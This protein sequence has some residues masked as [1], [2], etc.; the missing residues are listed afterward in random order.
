[1][2]DTRT[3]RLTA[4]PLTAA[5]WEPFGWLPV[6]DTD[7]ADN[8]HHYEFLWN[9]PH[10]NFIGHAYDE[11]EHVADGA[12][13]CAVMYRHDTHTQTLMPI[14]CEAI[15][16]VAPAGVDFS[17]PEHFETIRAFLLHPLDALVLF[18]GSWHWGP[19]PLGTEPVRLFNVQGRGYRDDNASVNLG[20]WGAR[21]EIRA[22][23]V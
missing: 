5:A 12:A 4:A 14:N 8:A 22:G 11:V 16:A 1:M 3:L 17:A 9:D 10:V 13:W 15:I 23:A 20:E 19:F 18:R 7:P 21:V 2:A 6:A